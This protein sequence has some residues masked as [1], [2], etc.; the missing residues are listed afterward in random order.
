MFRQMFNFRTRSRMRACDT[1]QVWSSSTTPSL[2]D[3][4]GSGS[5]AGNVFEHH[6]G[7]D[8]NANML[9]LQHENDHK[10]NKT[11]TQEK[12]SQLRGF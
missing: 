12:H 6:H 7:Q 4:Q 1:W 3:A 8:I 9:C 2:S 11:R 5:D 10:C